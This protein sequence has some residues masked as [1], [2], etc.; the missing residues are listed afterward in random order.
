MPNTP[1]TI[2][3][4]IEFV[5]IQA[6][7]SSDRLLAD[8]DPA[9]LVRGPQRAQHEPRGD[10]DEEDAGDPEEPAEVQA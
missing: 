9:G 2:A 7:R 4:R 3:P 1:V 6:D 10:E 5:G 8:V